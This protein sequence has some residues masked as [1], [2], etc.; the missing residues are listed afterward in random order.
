V[1]NKAPC[2]ED[3][4]CNGGKTHAVFILPRSVDKCSVLFSGRDS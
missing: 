4:Q 3:A 2:H 1:L